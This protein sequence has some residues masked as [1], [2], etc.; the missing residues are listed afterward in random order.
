MKS[1]DHAWLFDLSN[2]I[3]EKRNLVESH[4]EI[5]QQ[6]EQEHA[7]WKAGLP[8]PAWPSKPQR[9]KVPIDGVTYELNI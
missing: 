3:G 8:T 9:R 2:D 7:R 5:V 6:L 4:P 1:Y